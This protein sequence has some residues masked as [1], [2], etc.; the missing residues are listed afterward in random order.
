MMPP[1]DKGYVSESIRHGITRH[2]F[3]LD[4]VMTHSHPADRKLGI[5]VLNEKERMLGKRRTAEKPQICGF[6]I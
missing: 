3:V 1:F 6:N 4:L 5:A 2:F